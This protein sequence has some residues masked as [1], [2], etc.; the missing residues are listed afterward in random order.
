MKTFFVSMA[1]L[2]SLTTYGC[3]NLPPP[4]VP[5]T[6]VGMS[7]E[8]WDEECLKAQYKHATLVGTERKLAV[9]Q[10]DIENIFYYFQAGA[11]VRIDKGQYLKHRTDIYIDEP[12]K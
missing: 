6:H 11:L 10:C 8:E 7:F 12:G 3:V 1:L 2:I 9:Y 4:V 5:R